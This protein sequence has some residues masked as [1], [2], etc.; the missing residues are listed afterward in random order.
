M[1]ASRV[2]E[3]RIWLPS[4]WMAA[5]ISSSVRFLVD[6]CDVSAVLLDSFC[7]HLERHPVQKVT[8]SQYVRGLIARTRVD[9]ESDRGEVTG[10]AL[11]CDSDLVGERRQLY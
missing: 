8:N 11:R 2:D 5:A 9:I 7:T 10:C 6:Y 3:Q 1:S 4:E